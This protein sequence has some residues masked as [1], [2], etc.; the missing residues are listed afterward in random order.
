MD[1]TSKHCTG[2][3]V[4]YQSEGVALFFQVEHNEFYKLR[5]GEWICRR[6]INAISREILDRKYRTEVKTN[7]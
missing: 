6:C 7:E 5:S 1:N 4:G 3:K 2:C